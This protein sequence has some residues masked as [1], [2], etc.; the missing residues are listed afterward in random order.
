M[1]DEFMSKVPPQAIEMETAVIGALLVDHGAVNIAMD[2]LGEEMFYL[3]KHQ[4]I[5]IAAK[6]LFEN[7]IPIDMRSMTQQ[8]K[9]FSTLEQVGG[10]AVV[11]Q[12]AS[13]G[14][15]NIGKRHGDVIKHACE[16]IFEKHKERAVITLCSKAIQEAYSED[17]SLDVPKLVNGLLSFNRD[18][19]SA[20]HIYD[21]L[22]DNIQKLEKAAKNPEIL[23]G[24]PTG[25]D[26]LDK[27]TGGFK[28]GQ[29]IVMAA[30]PGM[31]KSV[32]VKQ[33]AVAAAMS[34]HPTAILSLEMSCQAVGNRY[35][36]GVSR[37][38]GYVLNNAKLKSEDWQSI[39]NA[40]QGAI[41]LPLWV[42]DTSSVNV[43]ELRAKVAKLVADFAIEEIIIDYLQLMSAPAK[44][45]S[46]EQEISTITRTIKQVAG[47]F[48]VVVVEVSSLNRSVDTRTDKTPVLSDLRESG[49]IESDADMVIFLYR[50]EYYGITD[51]PRGGRY[52]KGH[53]DVVIAKHR[54]GDTGIFSV[55]F[56]GAY[57]T[58]ANDSFEQDKE[59]Q[60]P[61][62]QQTV[63]DEIPF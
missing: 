11:M 47:D 19:K 44:G 12:L 46:R 40:A 24:I 55:T 9:A 28:K 59:P 58:F 7:R 52:D 34:G 53:T 51:N 30:R 16:I 56:E 5:F 50:P 54:E 57:S 18:K 3:H 35:L 2:M 60:K 62:S 39:T 48:G 63:T 31:G 41:E 21:I 45:Q 42:D 32:A 37:V 33:I 13:D 20:K 61:S 15:D 22:I 27:I 23:M 10:I 38:N 4:S 6:R 1:I 43:F 14:T 8:L 25:F 49:S 17:N 26:K 29:V 36:S